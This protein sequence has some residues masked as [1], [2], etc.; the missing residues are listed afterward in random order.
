MRLLIIED[1][2]RL[3]RG[4]KKGLEREGFAVDHI[5]D[6]EQAA[7]HVLVHHSSYDAIVLDLML[8]N[9]SGMDI[10]RGLRER[11]IKTPILILTARDNTADKVRMLDQGADDYLTKP[12]SL[13]ELSARLRAILRRPENAL[14]ADLENGPLRLEP[15]LHRVFLDGKQL[16]LTTKE[17]ALLEFFMR[18]PDQVLGRE[19]IL[20][21]VWDFNFNSFSNVVDVHVKNLRKKLGQGEERI[22][23]ETVSGVGYRFVPQVQE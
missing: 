11:G 21:H 13:S 14:P 4:L 6:G 17:F 19:H 10:C 2:E 22:F 7:K 20:E 16:Q 3:A 5:D 18:H 12:F 15:G 1:E 8:P 9:W 23:I